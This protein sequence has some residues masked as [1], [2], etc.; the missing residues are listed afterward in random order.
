[1][2]SESKSESIIIQR[3]EISF[4]NLYGAISDLNNW[5]DVLHN[6]QI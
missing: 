3:I 2:E 1:M 6:K 4:I 5:Y